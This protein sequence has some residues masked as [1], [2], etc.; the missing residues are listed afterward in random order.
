MRLFLLLLLALFPGPAAADDTS[1]QRVM[2]RL[3]AGEIAL[4]R[5]QPDLAAKRA[6]ADLRKY[7]DTEIVNR[8]V[9]AQIDGLAHADQ[10]GRNIGELL[11]LDHDGDLSI[12][13]AEIQTAT[14][15]N[16]R[17]YG[18]LLDPLRNYR[19]LGDR[20]AIDLDAPLLLHHV[21]ALAE[22]RA[23][24]QMRVRPSPLRFDLDGDGVTDPR[25][26]TAAIFAIAA[27]PY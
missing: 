5:S 23:A 18:A 26:V 6:I 20:T 15:Q 3:S 14:R 17:R 8:A 4:I 1:L 13:P 21:L 10:R 19:H 16:R 22:A 11:A 25:E 27:H 12:T 7:S 9:T 24:Q 2:D